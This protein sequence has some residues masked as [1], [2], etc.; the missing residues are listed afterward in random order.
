MTDAIA[1]V[2]HQ[3]LRPQLAAVHPDKPFTCS[4]KGFLM[5]RGHRFQGLRR[6][7]APSG[8]YEWNLSGNLR[9]VAQASRSDGF[10]G[11]MS[12]YFQSNVVNEGPSDCI[13]YRPTYHG[14]DGEDPFPD[15][16]ISVNCNFGLRVRSSKA[17]EYKALSTDRSR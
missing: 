12:G 8:P 2:L 3:K 5:P 11:G 4:E 6:S 14:L 7:V 17:W 16:K 13:S 9:Q 15:L 1:A 10:V